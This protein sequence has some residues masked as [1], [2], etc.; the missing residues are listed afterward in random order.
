MVERLRAPLLAAVRALGP[1]TPPKSP[2]GAEEAYDAVSKAKD[3]V[4]GKFRA[5][6]YRNITLTRDETLSRADRRRANQVLVTSFDTADSGPVLL[7]TLAATKCD[8]CKAALNRVDEASRTAVVDELQR[9]LMRTHQEE[10]RAAAKAHVGGVYS[11]TLDRVNIPL[12]D[13]PN[14]YATAVHELIH[15]LAHP[16]FSVA[17]AD[18]KN[19]VEGFTDYF[20]KD[21]V[22][23]TGSDYG[24]VTAD[25]AAVRRV[26][27]GPFASRGGAEADE[28]LRQAYFR[29]KLDLIGWVASD[30]TERKAVAAEGGSGE[31]SA[32]TAKAQ[33]EVY[34]SEA[35]A[36]QGARR[37]VL[38]MGLY[39]D[40]RTAGYPAISVRYARVV[41]R[42]EPY[43]RWQGLLEGQLFGAPLGN[44]K[45]FG[46]SVGVAAEYQEPY[47]YA[48]GGGRF[49]GTAVP[50][51]GANR[52]DASPFVGVG[53]RGWQPVR[54]GVEGFVL[55]PLAGG[56]VQ[57]GGALTVGIEIK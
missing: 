6:A 4:Y 32:A 29:G 2:V 50:G 41:L 38:G 56:G 42:E 35:L 40:T 24:D 25:V 28:S 39:F 15:A 46:A 1:G 53:W 8:T 37:N 13:R 49:V 19:I 14:V 43:A 47:F 23:S 7:A 9:T 10:I 20:T 54:V 30:D 21:V 55:L 26:L 57:G 12:K 18:E 36:A 52:L 48:Q 44:P 5:Y 16:A 17:F 45:A 33:A 31:W 3:A 11:R 51:G 34:R 27:Q 22:G